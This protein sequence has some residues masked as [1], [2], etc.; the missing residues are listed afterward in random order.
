LLAGSAAISGQRE[1]A[2]SSAGKKGLDAKLLRGDVHGRANSRYHREE[3]QLGAG[4]S[5]TH[6][7]H[8]HIRPRRVGAGEHLGD[9]V[10]VP[11]GS[12]QLVRA[13]VEHPT[14]GFP[15]GAFEECRHHRGPVADTLAHGAL[16]DHQAKDI[17]VSRHGFGC[18]E[19]TEELRGAV[20]SPQEVP[21]AVDHDRREGVVAAEDDRDR[22]L[23]P[24]H[25]RTVQWFERVQ[26]RETRGHK[27]VVALPERHVERSGQTHHHLA[28]R[29]G[30]PGLHEAHIA[31]RRGGIAG[32]VELALAPHRAPVT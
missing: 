9:I 3:R 12:D 25:Q 14:D 7:D 4:D 18:E 15:P 28:A 20:V 2:V 27:Q 21:G 26:R 29:L 24:G 6:I 19:T 10:S 17:G 8:R 22:L 31:R 11:Q 1:R 32:Q 23:D 5:E 30:S 16:L 13:A